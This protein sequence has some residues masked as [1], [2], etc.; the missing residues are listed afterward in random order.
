MGVPRFRARAAEE[1]S[2]DRKDS[3]VALTNISI[4]GQATK[5]LRAESCG[6]IGASHLQNC[7][8]GIVGRVTPESVESR[9]ASLD[10]T[11]K[12]ASSTRQ[13][14]AHSPLSLRDLYYFA[15]PGDAALIAISALLF[16]S[17]GAANGM[18]QLIMANA[19]TIDPEGS[20]KDA[21]RRAFVIMGC[22]MGSGV[23][24]AFTI[25][26]CCALLTRHRMMAK[27]K[28]NYLK[29]VLRQDIGWFD[30]NKPNELAGRM[31]E[32]MVNIEKAFSVATYIGLMPLSQ[33]AVSVIIALT[34][35][36]DLAALSL[37]LALLTA[38]PASIVLARTIA[39]RTCVLADAYGTAGGLC[40]EVLGA[41]RTVASLGLENFAV[42]KYDAAL[43]QAE[44]VAVRTTT[45]LAFAT[46]TISAFVFYSCGLSSLYALVRV[47]P[48]MRD[49]VFAFATANLSFCIPTACDLEY[50]P[51]ALASALPF[52]ETTQHNGVPCEMGEQPFLATC[53]SGEGLDALFSHL[54][55]PEGS[56]PPDMTQS[57]FDLAGSSWPC[58][59]V[60]FEV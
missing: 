26:S 36:P 20:I 23:A 54:G 10:N 49:S 37:A 32:A 8:R 47:V 45:K 34:A 39:Q 18:M 27:W 12:H 4:T 16:L 13:L 24:G 48:Q 21:G 17:V 41:V 22:I 28:V 50:N 3:A 59:G 40:A 55:W 5:T 30:V 29:S 2:E 1:S 46:A 52:R 6:K 35:V 19:M 60:D 14:E 53:A 15:T 38:V 25:G 31:G 33:A 58:N 51:Y 56:I 7:G 42:D 9:P 43:V 44:Q 57:A 11:M